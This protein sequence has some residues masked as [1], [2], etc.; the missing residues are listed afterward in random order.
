MI[1]QKYLLFLFLIVFSTKGR[2]QFGGF[3]H[4]VG[5]IAGP[6]SFQSDYGESYDF[7]SFFG[8]SGFSIGVV[9]YINFS[10]TRVCECYTADTYFNDH[11][12]IR[13]EISYN[14]TQL[15]HF[16]RDVDRPGNSIGTLQLRG[17]RGE[18]KLL[19][20][21]AQLE[22]FPLS[23]RE[24]S[25]SLFRFAPF[26]SLGGQYSNYSPKAWSLLG[27]LGNAQTTF[28]KYLDPTD[29]EPHGYTNRSGTVWS[30]VGSLGTRY[31]IAP[32]SDI[33][34]DFRLQYFFSNWI[35]GLNPDPIKHP[36]NKAND[37]LIWL[38]FGYI[39]YLQ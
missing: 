24:F 20:L 21:G 30:I 22:Y 15:K 28:P 37:L 8:N 11:F 1:K 32:L 16:G 18:A 35:D 3:S 38:N 31:K 17:M 19:N 5:V 6:I 26:V 25:S 2:S 36:E 39:Y 7:K 29:G 33:L 23:V 10:Y 9:H 27:P 34:L 4:E 13:S 12:K 14:A